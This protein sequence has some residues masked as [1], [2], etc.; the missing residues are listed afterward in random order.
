LA[1]LLDPK[2]KDKFFGGNIKATIKEWVLHEMAN[3][4][5]EVE[6]QPKS[7]AAK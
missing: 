6:L 4:T 2:F 5:V 3:V 1:I 7:I